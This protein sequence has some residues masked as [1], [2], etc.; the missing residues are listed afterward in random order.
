MASSL[1]QIYKDA[2]LSPDMH[3]AQVGEL[4]PTS[5]VLITGS[6]GFL[7]RYVVARLLQQTDLRLTM[8]ARGKPGQNAQSRMN[9]TLAEIGINVEKYKSRISVLDGDVAKKG[10]G[11]DPTS[12]N[13]L[14]G[15]VGTIYH[16]AAKVDWVRDYGRLRQTN[17]EGVRGIIGLACTGRT[18]RIVFSSSIA[19]S[20]VNGGPTRVCEDTPV[21]PLVAMMPLG[22]ARSKAVAETLL[23]QCADRGVP[24]T[25]VRPP[26]VSGHSVTGRCNPNDIFA[27]LLQ[28]C[29]R[30]GYGPDADWTFDIAPVDY[31]ARIIT[32]VPQGKNHWQVLN[33][34]QENARTWNNLLTWINLHG[35]EVLPMATDEWIHRLFEQAMARGLM[36]YT[37]RQYFSGRSARS[38]ETGWIRPFETY[39]ADGYAKIDADRT[40]NLL[41]KLNI[42]APQ[43]NIDLLHVYFND[44]RRVNVLPERPDRP[45]ASTHQSSTPSE[46][47]AK[48]EVRGPAAEM[49]KVSSSR[50]INSNSGIMHQL[51]ATFVQGSAGLQVLKGDSAS[52]NH[53]NAVDQK[54]L[55][56]KPHGS[57]LRDQ[58]AV[59]ASMS[60]S[61][62]GELFR[63]YDDPFELY[64]SH[65]RECSVYRTATSRMTPYM[66]KVFASGRR[67]GPDHWP[68]LMEYLPEAEM[69]ESQHWITSADPNM[70]YLIEDMTRLHAVWFGRTNELDPSI[71]PVSTPRIERMLEMAPLWVELA[72]VSRQKFE[73]F[74]S[75]Y[76]GLVHL[77][78]VHSLADWWPQYAMLPRTL[79]H[80]DFNPRNFA[81][82]ANSTPPRLC[83]YDWEIAAVGP[84][85]RD[86]AEL[87]CFTWKA[88]M[89]I[90]HLLGVLDR[91]RR[92]L[93]A[94]TGHKISY[95]IWCIGF[96]LALNYFLISRLP[97]YVMIENLA[98][99]SFLSTTI[100]NWME[101]YT[102]TERKDYLTANNPTCV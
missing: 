81:L 65:K 34:K 83:L 67:E 57:V 51:A 102:L 43:I 29:I 99:M 96:K 10:F 25:I 90:Q 18:K 70:K 74:G 6:T 97:L 40:A 23:K 45:A 46:N 78:I 61:R 80:N 26:L 38:G 76:F 68:I 63:R 77:D 14:T 11:I 47:V 73:R 92:L 28:A 84:P 50:P 44:F 53:F 12:Y 71:K 87:L 82:R 79:I 52:S 69:N 48:M 98:P 32:D 49:R 58:S 93:E 85:Q 64:D 30:T 1:D 19:V 36:L 94:E 41:K 31:V 89:G 33:I 42:E 62:L 60:S 17:V 16:C 100:S 91:S 5:T 27:A 2:V 101:L 39:L 21:L 3:L 24:V 86:L 9:K 88:G 35:Y 8:L 75:E 15:E 37:Q 22:Y 72:T 13:V 20:M 56:L 59:L 66:P 95:E 55:K 7:G 54:V 4:G